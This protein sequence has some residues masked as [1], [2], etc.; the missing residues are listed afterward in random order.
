MIHSEILNVDRQI[1]F[2]VRTFQYFSTENQRLI[3]IQV[4]EIGEMASQVRL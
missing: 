2:V 3:G 1:R 4:N